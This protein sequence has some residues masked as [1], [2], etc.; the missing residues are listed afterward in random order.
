MS[1][2]R[3]LL[4][5][6]IDDVGLWIVPLMTGDIVHAYLQQELRRLH[7]AVEE[8]LEICEGKE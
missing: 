7:Q 1:A 5:K 6:Q 4:E 8:H 3:E 2:L